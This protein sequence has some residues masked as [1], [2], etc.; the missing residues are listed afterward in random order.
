MQIQHGTHHV[1]VLICPCKSKRFIS[2]NSQTGDMAVIGTIVCAGD[3][4]PGILKQ[5]SPGLVNIVRPFR[6]GTGIII[7]NFQGIVTSGHIYQVQL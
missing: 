3:D 5:W 1:A 6:C 2:G 7:G 4:H